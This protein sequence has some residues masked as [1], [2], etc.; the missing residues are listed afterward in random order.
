MQK[1][2]FTLVVLSVLAACK[3]EKK[4]RNQVNYIV[5]GEEITIPDSSNIKPRIK[6]AQATNEP[7][8]LQLYSA[9]KIKAIPNKFAEIAAPFNGRI[10]ESY[11]KLGQDVQPGT[12]LFSIYSSDYTDAQKLYLQAKQQYLLAEKDYK[13][14]NDLLENGVGVQRDFE[15]A[16]TIY[17]NSKSE[18]EKS[19]A[20]IRIF[21]V[22]PDEMIFGEPLL[23]RSPIK[24]QVIKNSIVVGKYLTD[25]SSAIITVAEI[26]SVWITASVK[27]K[28]IRFIQEGDATEAQVIAYPGEF[29]TGKV[30]HIDEIVDEETRSINVLIECANRGEMLK[31]GMYATVKFTERPVTTVFVPSS[32]LLQFNDQNFVFV[33]TKPGS[34]KRQFV[35]TG[36]TVNGRVVIVEG[37]VG[38]ETII[39]EGGFYLLDAK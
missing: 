36:E 21:G 3:H 13:R 28:D 30:Y 8:K 10:T 6:L 27:E 16:K 26:S 15:T 20:S 31:P 39:S 11:V 19:R 2:F 17:E 25:N 37:L 23:V 9:A 35:K 34:Y 22:N 5:N 7:Y 38:S 33:Q 32:S 4:E 12:P 29:F 14:Q 18:F 1:A 24:G